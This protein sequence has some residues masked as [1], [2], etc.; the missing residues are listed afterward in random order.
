VNSPN[1]SV[2]VVQRSP[3]SSA[4]LR[5]PQR[6]S[7]DGDYFVYP[8]AHIESQI[9]LLPLRTEAQPPLRKEM[10]APRYR[11]IDPAPANIVLTICCRS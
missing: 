7:R 5:D 4:K 9:S 2:K 11:L 6:S 3:R 10:L 8:V 1:F